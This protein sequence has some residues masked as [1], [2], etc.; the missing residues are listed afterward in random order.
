MGQFFAKFQRFAQIYTLSPLCN[1]GVPYVYRKLS[2]A[3]QSALYKPLLLVAAGG[4]EEAVD[5][6]FF[7]VDQLRQSVPHAH[8]HRFHP[9]GVIVVQLWRMDG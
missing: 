2:Q 6:P 8:R 9:L 3:A 4:T 5:R 1:R 7:P